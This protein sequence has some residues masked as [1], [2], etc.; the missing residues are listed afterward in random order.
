MF[1]L[2]LTNNRGVGFTLIEVIVAVSV[3]M[4]GI[5][6]AFTV[7]TQIISDTSVSKNRLIANYLSQ[8]GIEIIR[9]IRDT[10]LI[11]GSTDPF[12]TWDSQFPAGDW[13]WEA[14]YTDSGYFMGFPWQL[15]FCIFCGSYDAGGFHLLK[16]DGGFYKY[17][18]SGQETTFKRKITTHK[19][20]GGDE[21]KVTVLVLWKEKNTVHQVSVQENIHKWD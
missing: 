16:I 3:V 20:I 6:G 12:I 17:S 7:T 14:D 5:V 1:N 4:T 21:L 10:N 18:G 15:D 2:N 19:D 8:E 13:D 11:K 9:N